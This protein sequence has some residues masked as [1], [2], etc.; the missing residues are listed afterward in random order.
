MSKA[1]TRRTGIAYEAF[2][3]G[4]EANNAK[5]LYL[6][7]TVKRRGGGYKCEGRAHY[8]GRSVYRPWASGIERGCDG[9]AEV[10]RGHIKVA[11][12]NRRAELEVKR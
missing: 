8:P 7:G 12:H 1:L 3:R 10:S 5:A 2:N 11:D 4:E 6:H 9:Y